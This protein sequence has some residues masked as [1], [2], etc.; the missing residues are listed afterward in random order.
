M[1]I[2]LSSGFFNSYWLLWDCQTLHMS[3]VW[4]Q[5]FLFYKS[6]SHFS[7]KN[8]INIPC[9]YL[10]SRFCTSLARNIFLRNTAARK[11][12]HRI[13]VKRIIVKTSLSS[14]RDLYVVYLIFF[15]FLNKQNAWENIEICFRGIEFCKTHMLAHWS[16]KR[17]FWTKTAILT[18]FPRKSK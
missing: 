17:T 7:Y 14:A 1:G 4:I 18:L 10:C 16:L 6:C 11:T 12:D 15:L 2:Q 9:G 3:V 8:Y 13:T 5:R